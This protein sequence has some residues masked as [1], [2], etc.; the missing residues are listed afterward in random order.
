MDEDIIFTKMD[1]FKAAIR[2]IEEEKQKEAWLSINGAEYAINVEE[3]IKTLKWFQYPPCVEKLYVNCSN[4][5]IALIDTLIGI[6]AGGS[7]SSIVILTWPVGEN[8]LLEALHRKRNLRTLEIH[9][10]GYF[11]ATHLARVAGSVTSLCLRFDNRLP[12]VEWAVL[13]SALA[14][15]PTLEKLEL[16]GQVP[17]AAFPPHLPIHLET[18]RAVCREDSNIPYE[19]LLHGYWPK[20]LKQL[21][22][23]RDEATE[24]VPDL[25]DETTLS[26]LRNLTDLEIYDHADELIEVMRMV[27]SHPNRIQAFGM[28]ARWSEDL[29]DIL[30]SRHAYMTFL[31]LSSSAYT[32]KCV[33]EIRTLV[34]RRTRVRNLSIEDGEGIYET[35][36]N[37]W[38][39]VKQTLF[40]VREVPRLSTR[41]HAGMLPL[42]DIMPRIAETLGWE[43]RRKV[44]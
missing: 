14:T 10:T 4:I 8:T 23:I 6:I 38:F 11:S 2:L 43:V 21:Y 28:S 29:W 22:L 3:Y 15:S 20:Q 34:R 31:G 1:I 13:G 32:Q 5:P 17:Q 44:W 7:Q 16:H 26:R 19:C 33:D 42:K 36:F 12:D 24:K 35:D 37:G 25:C 27:L 39:Q 9:D 30:T 40:S 18:F 41:C